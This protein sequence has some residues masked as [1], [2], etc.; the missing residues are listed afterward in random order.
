MSSERAY[1]LCDHVLVT[2]KLEVLE[3]ALENAQEL[4]LGDAMRRRQVVCGLHG[5]ANSKQLLAPTKNLCSRA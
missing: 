3:I 1:L 5:I 4:L 2:A